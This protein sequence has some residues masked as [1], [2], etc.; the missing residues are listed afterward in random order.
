M[1][2]S[3]KLLAIGVGLF[4][5]A[6]VADAIAGHYLD[7]TGATPFGTA[8]Y[9]SIVITGLFLVGGIVFTVLSRRQAKKEK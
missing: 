5:L 9:L 1:K 7:F 6:F 3:M 8:H 2:K 4:A